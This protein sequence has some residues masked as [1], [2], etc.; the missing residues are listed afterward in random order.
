MTLAE[1]ARHLRETHLR[2]R[3]E[4]AGEVAQE[5]VHGLEP[6]TLCGRLAYVRCK[7]GVCRS[8]HKSESLE[9]CNADKQVNA[10]RRKA[11]LPEV[12]R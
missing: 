8:C 2:A 1:R 5:F 3:R 9:D 12:S 4:I 7:D 10:M 6:C 11:G